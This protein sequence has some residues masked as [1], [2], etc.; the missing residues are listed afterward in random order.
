LTKINIE[1]FSLCPYNKEEKWD[2]TEALDVDSAFNTDTII[3]RRFS[4]SAGTQK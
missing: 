1:T 4:F 3:G 2:G